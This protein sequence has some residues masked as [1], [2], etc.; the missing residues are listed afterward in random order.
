MSAPQET[1]WASARNTVRVEGLKL[2]IEL[3]TFSGSLSNA[4]LKLAKW[5]ALKAAT[6]A[7]DEVQSMSQE[8][9]DAALEAAFVKPSGWLKVTPP[10]T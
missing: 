8:E 7:L 3:E 10:E 4:H 2:V 9:A 6:R 5:R 1:G